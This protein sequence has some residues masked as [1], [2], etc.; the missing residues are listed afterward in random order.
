GAIHL[1][2]A[3]GGSREKGRRL[4]PQAL[5]WIAVARRLRP[6]RIA[7]TPRAGLRGA[8]DAPDPILSARAEGDSGRGADRLAPPDAAGGDDPAGERG[9]LLLAA[10][11]IQGAAPD[12]ADRA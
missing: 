9:H 1:R 8:S 7:P 10:A 6:V 5:F 12:R 2:H 3:L 11:W 4:P